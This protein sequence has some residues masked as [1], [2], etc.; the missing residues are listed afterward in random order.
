MSG[1]SLSKD[2]ERIAFWASANGM[3]FSPYPPESW[4]RAWEPHDNIAPPAHYLHAVTRTSNHGP[5]VIVEPWYGSDLHSEPLERS[6]MAFAT[7]PGL[8]RRAAMRVGEHFLTRVAY[9]ESAPPPTVTLGDKLW[10]THVTTFAAS[11]LEAQTAFHPRLRHL[12][13]SW[14]F[15]GHLELRPGGLVVFMAGLRPV[16]EHYNRLLGAAREILHAAVAYA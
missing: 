15:Q 1:P 11:P 7:H 2:A 12:L 14:G 9:L 13:A 6:I 16:P 8:V 4:L 10:D 5:Y 3:A